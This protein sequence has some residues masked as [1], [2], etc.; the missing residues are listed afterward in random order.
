MRIRSRIVVFVGL[1]LLAGCQPARENALD[2]LDPSALFEL[3]MN[4]RDAAFRGGDPALAASYFHA[5]AERGHLAAQK[6]IAFMYLSGFG[7]PKNEQDGL[8]Y[9]EMAAAQGDVDASNQAGAMYREGAGTSQDLVRAEKAFRYAAERYYPPAMENLAALYEEGAGVPQSYETAYYWRFLAATLG[10]G[11]TTQRRYEAA[12]NLTRR[13]LD[14]IERRVE[15]IW[16]SQ[17]PAGAHGTPF[18]RRLEG[19]WGTNSAALI[20]TVQTQ[21]GQTNGAVSTTSPDGNGRCI[22]SYSLPSANGTWLLSCESG[23]KAAGTLTTYSPVGGVLGT[24]VD[25]SD[26]QIRFE[27]AATD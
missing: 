24:G 1:I 27:I 26:R 10:R 3:G 2:R 9:V 17:S 19:K 16:T 15:D 21:L 5:A 11:G 4:Y 25:S 14:A 13:Q 22:G 20:G 7:V 12:I 8:R 18:V 23:I 6:Y